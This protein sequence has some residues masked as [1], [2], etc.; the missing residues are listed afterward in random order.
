MALTAVTAGETA[1]AADLNQYR[2]HLQG[3][4]SSTEAWLLR[5]SYGNVFIIVLADAA[6]VRKVSF[7]DSGNTEVAYI[8]SDG[9]ASFASLAPTSLTIPSAAAPSQT[10]EGSA[11]WDSSDDRLT[12]GTG[13]ATKVIGLSREAGSDASATQEL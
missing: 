11:V 3:D 2:L 13:S 12:I 10:A 6:G 8:D 4:A 9:G 1:L 5:C 7:R